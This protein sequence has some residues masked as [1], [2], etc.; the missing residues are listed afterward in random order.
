MA[1]FDKHPKML[2]C[3]KCLGQSLKICITAE[4][5]SLNFLCPT[6]VYNQPSMNQFFCIQVFPPNS[7]F[8]NND[9][10][11]F[12]QVGYFKRSSTTGYTSCI[13]Y[14]VECR[15]A[16][17]NNIITEDFSIEPWKYG[18]SASVFTLCM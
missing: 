14:S 12:L 11:L 7:Y 15:M 17:N 9:L 13:S 4:F 10:V 16:I 6:K 8:T 1:H 18:F 5:F 2:M 3:C